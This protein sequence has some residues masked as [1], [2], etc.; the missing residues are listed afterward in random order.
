MRKIIYY[1]CTIFL[2]LVLN[3][4]GVR[5]TDNSKILEAERLL[6]SDP[7]SA[8]D[9][10]SSIKYPE[11]MSRADYAAW[12]LHYTHA[13][14]KCYK[15]IASD[16]LIRIA[17][18]YF[19]G[20]K[21]NKYSGTAYYLSGCISELHQDR[22]KAMLAYENAINILK[23]TEEYNIL[24]LSL[25]NKGYIYK[26]NEIYREAYDNFKNSLELFQKTENKRYMISAY[27]EISNMLLQLNAPFDSIMYYSNKA[28]DLANEIEHASLKYQIISRQGELLSDVDYRTATNY[29]LAGYNNE[30]FLQKRNASFL[31]YTY[32]HMGMS[33]SAMYYLDISKSGIL[34]TESEIFR[35][36]AQAKIYDNE[37]NYKKALHSMEKAYLKQDTVFR[38]KLQKQLYHIDKQFDLTEK[39]KE[40]TKL[41]IS[42]RNKVIAIEILIIGVLAI[43]LILTLAV[44]NHRKKQTAYRI[45]QHKLEFELRNRQL[46]L[47]KKKELLMSKLKQRIELTLQFH[48]LEQKRVRT[49]KSDDL[50]A[51]IT[52]QIML[53]ESEWAYYIDEADSIFGNK[54]SVLQSKYSELTAHDMIVI[55]LICLEIGVPDSCNLLNTSKN[56]MYIRR[57]RIKK[58]LGIDSEADLSAWLY[59]YVV[60]ES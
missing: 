6:Y 39:E 38:N 36:L 3:F 5:Y 16:S 37:S 15:E 40:N 48:N 10:L 31:A 25:F 47:E 56:T 43:L 28:L 4:C 11:R 22:E 18:E 46:E 34:D 57:K 12:C 19:N 42:N 14:Y 52:D 51:M 53:K 8:Y 29:L 13:Q 41:I 26:Q 24:G 27:L 21:V 23:H 7:D 44:I 55:V 54:L 32:S 2:I 20:S 49:S 45:N 59:N 35:Y 9:I 17:L 58:R 33:D 30:P 50:L 1:S 60:D